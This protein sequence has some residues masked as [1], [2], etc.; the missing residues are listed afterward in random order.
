MTHETSSLSPA[1]IDTTFEALLAAS[2]REL[3]RSLSDDASSAQDELLEP[4]G[5]RNEIE[6]V[7]V[8][9]PQLKDEGF[10]E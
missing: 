2:R 8:H 10:L 5:Q 4:A 9:L 3:L 7:H 1:A 6:W